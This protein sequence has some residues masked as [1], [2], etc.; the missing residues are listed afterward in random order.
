VDGRAQWANG[1]I[2]GVYG[3]LISAIILGALF[4]GYFF[5]AAVLRSSASL[6][7]KS[8]KAVLRAPMSFY[9][10]TPLGQILS[11]FARHLFLVDD[12]LPEAA[13]QFL[14]YSPIVLGT[15]VLLS[16]VMPWFLLSLPFA[17]IAG[18]IL[19]FTT[20]E[21]EK[22]LR[23]LEGRFLTVKFFKIM[24]SFYFSKQQVTNVFTFVSNLRRPFQYSP[25]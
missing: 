10:V 11:N 2:V 17:I 1:L 9:D 3:G 12:S 15:I 6:H 16:I 23:S 19:V 20:H 8:L 18:Y 24:L 21:A 22:R 5:S 7:D 25:L 14:S 4:R 13:L